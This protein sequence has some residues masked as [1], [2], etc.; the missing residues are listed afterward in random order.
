[1]L[2]IRFAK[3][4]DTDNIMKFIHSHWKENHILSRN[5]DLFLYE[6]QDNF[7]TPKPL[8]TF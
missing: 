7:N 8:T 2:E 3:L 1:M 4:L 5:K 6:Y